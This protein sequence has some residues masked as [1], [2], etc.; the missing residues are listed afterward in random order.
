MARKKIKEALEAKK[1]G[2]RKWT[3]EVSEKPGEYKGRVKDEKGLCILEIR[4]D[5]D[6]NTLSRLLNTNK[7]MSNKHDMKGLALYL[8]DRGLVPMEPEEKEEWKKKKITPVELKE[9]RV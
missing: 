2:I 5:I 4:E 3:Y 8:W 9:V 7:Y 1:L 6:Y